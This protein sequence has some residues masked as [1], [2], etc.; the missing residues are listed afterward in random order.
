LNQKSK[1]FVAG[2]RGL[3]GSAIIQK[4]KEKGYENIV[5][6]PR[7]EVNYFDARQLNTF[8]ENSRPEYIFL[9]AGKTGGIQANKNY[10][11]DFAYENLTIQNNF[12]HLA[13]KF[14]V[15]SLVF[16]GSSCVYPKQS[17]QPMTESSLFQGSLEITSLPYATA[18]IAGIVSC[19]AY[20]QQYP[21]TKMICL[22]PNSLYGPCD[23]FDLE[24]SHVLSAMIRKI[25]DAK[26]SNSG[27]LEL[28]G[29]GSPRREFLF[30]SDAAEA[31]IFAVLNMNRLENSHYNIGTGQD[32]SIS[33][34]SQ[35]I[36]KIVDYKGEIYF[37]STKPDGAPRKLLDSS[38]F[39]QLGWK[40]DMQLEKG[41]QLTYE[42]F[43]K[44][45][46]SA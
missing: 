41:I 38:R 14:K 9:A 42:W 11:A 10:P 24:N 25:H 32:I 44:N 22:L 31:S 15:K 1:I 29:T 26:K 16:Y 4:L 18:K 33:E 19:Q 34:L 46:I 5:T 45:S 2:H 3:L 7:Q 36:C 39:F 37:D 28:W 17:P 21:E 43:R 40:P 6:A 23:N 30:S 20:N 8:I 35:I 12:F 13:N 27:R